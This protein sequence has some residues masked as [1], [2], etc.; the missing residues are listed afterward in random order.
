MKAISGLLIATFALCNFSFAGSP[1]AD[2]PLWVKFI[3][4]GEFAVGIYSMTHK[5]QHHQSSF[6][7]DTS[8][9][10]AI[11][12]LLSDK[13]KKDFAKLK[14]PDEKKVYVDEFWRSSLSSEIPPKITRGEFESRCR[15]AK[16]RFG[17]LHNAG[18]KTDRGRA[19]ILYGEPDEIARKYFADTSFPDNSFRSLNDMEVWIYH[20]PGGRNPVPQCLLDVHTGG[21]MFVFANTPRIG[22]FRQIYSTEPGEVMD[23]RLFR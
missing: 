7:P 22:E 20:K 13:Q 23:M 4:A 14:T 12:Y 16:E 6:N 1:D 11:T 19:F 5:A 9:A 17:S 8:E 18:W 10:E 2:P 21:M 15:S 3:I